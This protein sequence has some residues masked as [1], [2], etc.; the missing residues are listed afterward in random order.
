MGNRIG[1]H[2]RHAFC[3]HYEKRLGFGQLAGLWKT[4]GALAWQK[5]PILTTSFRDSDCTKHVQRR[6]PS[7]QTQHQEAAG[8][9]PTTRTESRE[10]LPPLLSV[11]QDHSCK[12]QIAQHKFRGEVNQR[13]ALGE[14]ATGLAAW[15]RGY[16]EARGAVPGNKW[17]LVCFLT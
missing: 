4:A 1:F 14:I 5:A 10:P 7:L 12:R 16:G 17:L 3:Q 6:Q 15:E 8:C 2:D 11:N 13:R 9:I